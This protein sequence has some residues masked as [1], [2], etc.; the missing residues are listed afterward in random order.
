MN[1]VP[2]K[3]QLKTER[4]MND[5]AAEHEFL[6]MVSHELR[7]PTA[8]ILGWADLLGRAGFPVE[9]ITNAAQPISNLCQTPG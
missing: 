9:P 3:R 1:Q 6:T 7:T 5:A 8:A 2:Y 4:D